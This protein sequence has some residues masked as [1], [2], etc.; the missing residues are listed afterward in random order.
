MSAAARFVLAA[1]V[2]V[3]FL[4]ASAQEPCVQ[5]PLGAVGWW[6]GDNDALD[7]KGG[8]DGVLWYG[9]SYSGGVVGAA[10]NLDGGD[11]YVE[12]ADRDDLTPP[13]LTLGAWVNPATMTGDGAIVS[14]YD[15]FKSG[16]SWILLML[17]GGRLRFGVYGDRTG[18]PKT[19]YIDSNEP[20]LFSNS[21]QHVA[22]TF[23]DLTKNLKL[24]VNG[25]EVPGTT[26]GVTDL[27]IW[28]SE[29]P[30]RI[31]VYVDITNHLIAHWDG[32]IDE[33]QIFSRALSRCEIKAMA[34]ARS[35]GACKGDT[36]GDGLLDFNDNCPGLSNAGQE[37]VD[38]D[39]AGD[40]CDCAPADPGV[41]AA[42]GEVGMLQVRTVGDN[43]ELDWCS[44]ALEAGIASVYDVPRG[45]LN[46]FPVGTG[47]SE[48]CLPP[49]SFTSPAATDPAVPTTSSGFWY[50]VRSRNG[51]GV[52]TYGFRSNGTERA[53]AVCP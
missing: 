25:T 13:S 47:V 43:S 52:G 51:C 33:V 32:I 34:D 1:G 50:L 15:S 23:D 2:V 5:L 17:A 9:A 36:D 28:N 40:A 10:F 7:I 12:I 26:Y 31:G 8:N 29:T 6:P 44:S 21:F 24:Y 4:H 37:N 30:V 46:E 3:S 45:T 35:G 49:G 48:T 41:F 38:G 27:S 19:R 18:H 39:A 20:V 11:D 42:P 53:T 16:T 22:A 14:K